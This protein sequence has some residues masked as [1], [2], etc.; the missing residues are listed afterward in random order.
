MSN[1]KVNL[2]VLCLFASLC[3][4]C[5]FLSEN[6]FQARFLVLLRKRLSDVNILNSELRCTAS[7]WGSKSFFYQNIYLVFMLS[8]SFSLTWAT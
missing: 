2:L 1:V 8:I 6:M 7:L 4:C 3:F 5:L